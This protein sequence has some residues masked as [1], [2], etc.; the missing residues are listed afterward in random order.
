MTGAV[1]PDIA[2]ALELIRVLDDQHV[3]VAEV[4]HMG[5][6]HWYR[7]ADAAPPPGVTLRRVPAGGDVVSAA[8]QLAGRIGAHESWARTEDRSARTRPAREAFM[9]RFEREVDPGGVLPPAERAR[10]AEHARKAFYA[11]IALKSAAARRRRAAS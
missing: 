10:R 8:H 6:D 11:R 9:A 5:D 3:A 7:V 4:E 2:D 1:H